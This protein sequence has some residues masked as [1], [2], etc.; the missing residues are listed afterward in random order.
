MLVVAALTATPWLARQ[1][2]NDIPVLG[3]LPAAEAPWNSRPGSF[4]VDLGLPDLLTD[5]FRPS[6]PSVLLPTAY[7]DLWGDYFGNF[8]W[9]ASVEPEPRP[10]QAT[11]LAAQNWIGLFPTVLALVG[12]AALAALAVARRGPAA[13]RTLVVALPALALVG[14]VYYA[15]N[16]VTPDGDSIKGIYMVSATPGWALAFGFALQHV[17][18]GRARTP[19]VA[20]LVLIALANMRFLVA[21]SPLGGLL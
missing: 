16:T 18:R 14:F 6:F 5:P 12:A 4:F 20:T 19:V 7:S 10:G 9:N 11:E 15:S 8:V 1:R 17:A 3:Q 21:G 13:P 2:A